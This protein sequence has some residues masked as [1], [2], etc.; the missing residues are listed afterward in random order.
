MKKFLAFLLALTM[1]LGVGALAEENAPLFQQ[2]VMILF[3]SDV[4]CGIESN[5]GYAGLAMVRDAYKN[6]GYHVLLVDNGDSIQGEPV[7]TMTTGEANIKLMNAVG[8]DIATMGNHEF[9]YGM[10]RFF[11]LSKMANFPYISCNFNKGGELQF[12]PYVIKE[13]DGVKIA[14]VGITTPKT[15]TSSTPKYFQDE[16]G[17][18]IYGFFEDETGEGL[19]N[20]VQKA[21]D[22][23]RAEGASIV[24]AM[25]HLGNEAEC[26]PYTYKDVIANTTGINALLDGHSHDTDHVEMRNKARET[27]LRQ[28]CGTKLEGVG[29]LKIAAKNGAMKAGVMMWNNDDFNATQLYQLDTDVTK[30]VAEATETLNAKLAEVV[31]KTDVELTIN[32]PVAVTEDGKAVRIIR[33]AETN[34]GDL[35]A[36]AYRY[37]S[38]ADIAFVNGG[39]IRVSIKEGDITLNDILKVHPFGNALCVCEATGQQILDALEFGAKDVPGE[40]GGFL[41]VSGLTYEIH[42]SVPSSVKLDE[43]GLFAG[44]EGE[45]RVKNVMV[46]DEPLDL[47]KIYTLASHN[48]MLQG[49]G[50]GYTIFEDNVYTQES[51]MLDNQVLITYITE[52]LGG[53]VGAEYAN[54]YG[55]GRIVAVD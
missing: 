41:Q 16:N 42:T 28:G 19:Y 6:A 21:V 35:C 39:G 27:V 26:S 52:G 37:V 13:F 4:H 1:L 18:F 48:Y 45:Y 12:A 34:L 31:A 54:P 32:D 23:A 3:T 17:N 49:Q 50:D 5:F 25:A 11:E 55:Q 46:G 43:K 20:A 33:N 8:Y 44:V 51:V 22:D 10:D 24:I 9:D 47:E 29:Y 15:L 30:A 14:F 38:G 36:D 53:V 2:D 40:F 7:G